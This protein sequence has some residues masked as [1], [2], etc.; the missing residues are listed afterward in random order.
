MSIGARDPSPPKTGVAPLVSTLE[1]AVK[2]VVA[3]TSGPSKRAIVRAASKAKTALRSKQKAA[4]R[5]N[6][7]KSVLLQPSETQPRAFE[8][9][10]GREGRLLLELAERANSNGDPSM[11][12]LI[13]ALEKSM[14]DGM[15][16]L[17]A[18]PK[19]APRLTRY[20][21]PVV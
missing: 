2:G 17:E 18:G 15:L 10:Y 11:A 1:A 13:A 7:P 20:V 19:P 21:Y 16:E 5:A 4:W 14:Q 12:C 9:V 6:A 3:K 8:E